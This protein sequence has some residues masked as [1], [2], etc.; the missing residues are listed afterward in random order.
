MI[1]KSSTKNYEVKI[2]TDFE[3]ANLINCDAVRNLATVAKECD[4]T[5]IH[6]STDYVYDSRK[7]ALL[8]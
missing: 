4:I 2:G 8:L 7:A 1:I 5:L 3:M 6:I